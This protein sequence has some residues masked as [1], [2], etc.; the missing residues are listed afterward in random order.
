MFTLEI[1]ND[2]DRV[3]GIT[4]F[5]RNFF[6]H[7][8]LNNLNIKTISSR[9]N[10]ELIKSV[11]KCKSV[12][13]HVLYSLDFLFIILIC[14]M[15][16]KK[17]IIVSHGNLIIRKKSKLK[18]LSFLFIAKFLSKL[19]EVKTQFL[20]KTEYERSFKISKHYLI[21]PPFI[22]IKKKK[23]HIKKAINFFIWEPI[24]M[25]EKVL[26]ECWNLFRHIKKREYI[27]RLI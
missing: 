11:Y 7:Q 24:I 20:N 16:K 22:N 23:I 5:S 18:K 17:L 14:I 15:F 6:K 4:T 3:S 10:I 2:P 8:Y 13:C 25:K 19:G 27:A 1:V 26:I 21:C 12:Y 9:L